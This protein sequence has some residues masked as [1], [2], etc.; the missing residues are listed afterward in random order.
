MA[1]HPRTAKRTLRWPAVAGLLA[2]VATLL[3]GP[4]AAAGTGLSVESGDGIGLTVGVDGSVRGVRVG[5]RALPAVGHG[6]FSV[7][8]VGGTPNLVPNAGLERDLDG[9]GVP[10]GWR[11]VGF[12]AVPAIDSTMAHGGTRSVR[13]QTAQ[14]ADSAELRIDIPV[15]AE[16]VYSL[17][18]WIRTDSLLPTAPPA[19]SS[20]HLSA[21]RVVVTQAA[22]HV[23]TWV[24]N[25]FGYTNTADWHRRSLGVRT[26]PGTTSIGIALRIRDGKGTV[27]FDDLVLRELLAPTAT[28]IR[29]AVTET[30][31][32]EL[33][34]QAA[35][36]GGLDFQATYRGSADRI[37][38]DARISST[39]AAD[40]PLEVS[41]TLPINAVGWSWDDYARRSRTIRAGL[42]YSYETEWNVQSMSRYPWNTI[43]DRRSAVSMGVPLAMPRVERVRYDSDGLTISFDLGLSPRATT[44]GPVATFRIVLFTSDPAWGFRSATEHYYAMQPEAFVHRTDPVREGGWTVRYGL[45]PWSD[46]MAEMGMG[47]DSVPLGVDSGGGQS[48]FPSV[49]AA[50]N[51]DATYG[52]AYNHQWGYKQL[53]ATPGVIPT[54]PEAVASLEAEAAG[55]TGTF[56]EQRLVDLA[57]ATLA[58]GA[59]DENRRLVYETYVDRYL[60][61]YEDLDPLPASADDWPTATGTY[62]VDTALVAAAGAGAQLDGIHLDSTS[63]MRRWAAQ[64]DYDRDHWAAAAMPLT[65][66]YDTGQVVARVLFSDY[67]QVRRI[68]DE[69]HGTGRIVSANFNG[70]EARA[71]AW[72]GADAIDYFGVEQGLPEKAGADDPYVTIDSFAMFKRTLADQRPVSTNDPLIGAG[73]L[74]TAQVERRLQRNLFYG[75]YSGVGGG[76]SLSEGIVALYAHYSPMFRALGAAGWQPLTRARADDQDV[77]L[78]RFGSLAGDVEYLTLRN[79]TRIAQSVGVTL[80]LR[81][82]P[83]PPAAM[84]GHELV[85]D[86]PVNVE[87]LPGGLTGTFSASVPARSTR[88]VRLEVTP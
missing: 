43:H 11:L 12:G 16:T 8:K 1:S 22:G 3:P 47:L 53:L 72:F 69:M 39:T 59:R 4:G 68:A 40:R 75:I 50:D 70:S 65:F 51:A 85:T 41:Y 28:P 15:K 55:P 19:Q 58:S 52:N 9:N 37:T 6:G 17:R 79:D 66:S 34:Q 29:G 67:G 71:G 60:Q 46:R 83:A 61:W 24:N 78:E 57:K 20:D 31:P 27:W 86:A 44:L 73:L 42:R 38:I 23:Q 76:Y 33:D 26:L 82:A 54:Y 63:G 10:D 81:E 87:V 45:G 80:S 32:D 48:S 7:R 2:I 74:T 56:Q 49:L 35:L 64:D 62:E 18:A 14:I 36:P 13:I 25:I 5:D 30:A 77:W 84:S 88:V 21:A